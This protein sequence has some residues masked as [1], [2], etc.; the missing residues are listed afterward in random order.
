M[1]FTD[2]L[3]RY[4]IAPLKYDDNRILVEKDYLDF[5]KILMKYFVMKFSFEDMKSMF[6]ELSKKKE[7]TL[8]NMLLNLSEEEMIDILMG[9]NSNIVVGKA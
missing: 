2:V 4:H 1:K 8:K 5:F 3:K 9:Q 6:D 7:F